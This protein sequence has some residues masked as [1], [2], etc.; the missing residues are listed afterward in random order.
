A[1]LASLADGR[2]TDALVQ[3]QAAR[4]R[5]PLALTPLFDVSAIQDSAGNKAAAQN[6]LE[7]GVRLQPANPE[8]WRQL[9]A[10]QLNNLNQ[11]TPAFAALRAA[12]FL[13]PKNPA[14]QAEFLD[15]YRRLPTRPVG[16]GPKPK[17]VLDQLQR[18]GRNKSGG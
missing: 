2:T 7:Q 14:I 11:P 13:D 6:A 5:N 9:A 16:S 4:D 10:Y 18:L 1:A 3:A 17:G 8:S 15:A 12:L